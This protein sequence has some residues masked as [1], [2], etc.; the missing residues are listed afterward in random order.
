MTAEGWQSRVEDTLDHA[1]G[2]LLQPSLGAMLR[3]DER[4][5]RR[6]RR[7]GRR[8]EP[9]LN[10]LASMRCV[11][12]RGGVPPLKGSAIHALHDQL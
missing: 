1:S 7:N 10:E 4:S 8:E 6:S 5:V 3:G 9:S 2:Q 12:C 11:P